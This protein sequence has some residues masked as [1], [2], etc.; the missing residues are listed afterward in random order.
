MNIDE[1]GQMSST[2]FRISKMENEI[3]NSRTNLSC[4]NH[5]RSLTICNKKHTI[6]SKL[7]KYFIT[8][9]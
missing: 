4:N 3:K 9:E 2:T 5:E 8:S 7:L 1:I 6:F